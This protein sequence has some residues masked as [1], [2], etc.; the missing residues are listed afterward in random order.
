MYNSISSLFRAI[1]DVIRERD[2]TD[3]KIRHQEIPDRIRAIEGGGTG[4]GNIIRNLPA[5]EME[6][7]ETMQI[8]N[9]ED[10]IVMEEN[11]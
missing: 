3:G 5:Y 10:I 2:G 1:C 9:A 7:D 11:T 4:E 8:V 6:L